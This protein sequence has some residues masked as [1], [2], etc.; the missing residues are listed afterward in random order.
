M[1]PAGGLVVLLAYALGRLAGMHQTIP[2]RPIFQLVEHRSRCLAHDHLRL[3]R[4]LAPRLGIPEWA[5]AEL[6]TLRRPLLRRARRIA[7]P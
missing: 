7:P 1:V 3:Q 2:W 4:E 6:A 5:F